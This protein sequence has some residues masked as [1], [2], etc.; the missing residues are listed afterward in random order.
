[1]PTPT[2]PQ[3]DLNDS[4]R[5]AVFREVETI[6]RADPTLRR[7][8]KCW[9]SW[10][11]VPGDAQELSPAAGGPAVRLTPVGSEEQFQ[12]PDA[13]TGTLTIGVEAAVAGT[14]VDDVL[15]LWWAIERAIYPADQA[16][17]FAIQQA[18]QQAGSK[19]GLCT[20]SSPS[21]DMDAGRVNWS[22]AGQIKTD[23]L[24]KLNT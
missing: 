7:V 10:Q 14:C 6:L 12:F 4:P 18:I 20:F 21:L 3:L 15:N 24:L 13:Q 19:T 22:I 1:M 16:A 23:V 8:V 17:K 5:T 2:R 11:G 9:R